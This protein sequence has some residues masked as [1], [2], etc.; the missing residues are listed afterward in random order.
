M[1]PQAQPVKQQQVIPPALSISGPETIPAGELVILSVEGGEFTD[2][3]WT[4]DPKYTFGS[5]RSKNQIGFATPIPGRYVIH[6]S[7][8]IDDK[9]QT[10]VHTVQIGE[11]QQP[12][13]PPSQGVDGQ[14]GEV[15]RSA[16]ARGL[17]LRDS[18]TVAL[19]NEEYAKASQLIAS[20][21]SLDAAADHFVSC[22]TAAYR[23]R[24]GK[25]RYVAWDEAWS[26][27]L[28]RDIESLVGLQS[29]RTPVELE[30]VYRGIIQGM[31]K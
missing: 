17:S 12:N 18:P 14:V 6:A 31:T 2:L 3:A 19:L 5:L 29:I 1:P 16:I 24:T 23:R 30:Q 4:W 27:P 28:S 26:K 15:V 25:S 9:L 22:C 10:A 8:I 11:E 21:T 20:A 13:P 7:A